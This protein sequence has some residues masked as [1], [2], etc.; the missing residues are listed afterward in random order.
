MREGVLHPTEFSLFWLKKVIFK[1]DFPNSIF[2]IRAK[3]FVVIF[4]V[5]HYYFTMF[6][7][8]FL[9]VGI[10]KTAIEANSWILF[11]NQISHW[12]VF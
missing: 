3:Y 11:N 9:N 10:I 8:L 2:H 12:P 5:I 6:T 1:V 7:Y 4:K